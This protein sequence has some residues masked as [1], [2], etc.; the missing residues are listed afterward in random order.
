MT[1]KTKEI[2]EPTSQAEEEETLNIVGKGKVLSWG[3]AGGQTGPI[4]QPGPAFL[5]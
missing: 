1:C 5:I 4:G 3:G 2:C